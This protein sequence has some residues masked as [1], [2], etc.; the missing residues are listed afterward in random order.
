MIN[1]FPS[2][3]I[4][5][6]SEIIESDYSQEFMN[7]MGIIEYLP[8]QKIQ[9][10]I[11]EMQFFFKDKESLENYLKEFDLNDEALILI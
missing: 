5:V 1:S 9:D 2:I 10:G 3:I 4:D 6:L 7:Q 11:E 8:I